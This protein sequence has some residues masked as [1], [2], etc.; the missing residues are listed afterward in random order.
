[1]QVICKGGGHDD[2]NDN[3]VGDNDDN[4][5]LCRWSAKLICLDSL[6]QQWRPILGCKLLVSW[7]QTEKYIFIIFHF[8]D[9]FTYFSSLHKWFFRHANTETQLGFCTW[10]VQY[11][12]G[13][14]KLFVCPHFHPQTIKINRKS[15]KEG[16]KSTTPIYHYK[17][18]EKKVHLCSF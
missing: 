8:L 6:I 18:N 3:D 10:R 9:T 12:R 4:Y 7:N 15:L 14:K 17:K 2:D 11:Q 13:K 5:V 1:M 16:K